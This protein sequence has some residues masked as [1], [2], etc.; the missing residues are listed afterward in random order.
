MLL[1]LILAAFPAS[2]VACPDLSG[3]FSDRGYFLEQMVQ[4]GCAEL[5]M[6]T[7][8]DPNNP[9]PPQNGEPDT[10]VFNIDCQKHQGLFQMD[11]VC[12]NKDVLES[13]TYSKNVHGVWAPFSIRRIYLD[14]NG[15]DL[16]D[17]AY[18]TDA[19]GDQKLYQSAIY[20]RQAKRQAQRISK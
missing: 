14:A 6:I 17:D 16:H 12:W 18:A 15:R 9:N 4:K 2:S 5:R 7:S 20:K 1:A 10:Q 8:T 11:A 3:T 13:W 19:S